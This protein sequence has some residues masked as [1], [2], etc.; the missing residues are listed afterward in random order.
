MHKTTERS[1]EYFLSVIR[2]EKERFLTAQ[3]GRSGRSGM[4]KRKSAYFVRNDG[5]VAVVLNG[6]FEEERAAR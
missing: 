2:R 1:N 6:A 3:A 4:E 5:F